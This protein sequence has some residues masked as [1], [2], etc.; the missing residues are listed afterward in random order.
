MKKH[1]RLALVFMM[2]IVIGFLLPGL[3]LAGNLE[4]SGSP[5]PTMR[6]LDEIYSANSWSKKL[7]CDQIETI[8]GLRNI[9]PRFEVL[10]DFNNEA[11]LDKETGLVWY[12]SPSTDRFDWQAAQGRCNEWCR[13]SSAGRCG[14]RLPTVQ[15]LG[16]LIDPSRFSLQGGSTLPSG[17]PFS[18]VQATSCSVDAYWSATT[19]LGGTASAWSVTFTPGCPPNIGGGLTNENYVWCVRGGSG[20]DAQ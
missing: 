19:V 15:E 7:Q 4:P 13:Y 10:A 14:W 16:S 6:T 20:I 11:V 5:A 9:C 17:N 8:H 18:N 3:G 1:G 12:Q 2:A